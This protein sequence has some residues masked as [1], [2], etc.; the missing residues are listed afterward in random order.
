MVNQL[1]TV[2]HCVLLRQHVHVHIHS[3]SSSTKSTPVAFRNDQP[4]FSTP[5]GARFFSEMAR[6]VSETGRWIRSHNKHT[7]VGLPLLT[8]LVCLMDA[9]GFLEQVCWGFRAEW[10]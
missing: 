5:T 4:P 8:Q 2:P 7:S 10:K 3:S 6:M 1:S 9:R